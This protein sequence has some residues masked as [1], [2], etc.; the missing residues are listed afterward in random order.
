MLRTLVWLEES[1]ILGCS[2]CAWVFKPKGAPTGKSQEEVL[3]DFLS[4]RDQQF[5]SHICDQHPRPERARG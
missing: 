3:Q 5:A 2:E 4:K 1:G